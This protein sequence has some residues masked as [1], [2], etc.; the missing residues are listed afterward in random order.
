MKFKRITLF[1]T[2]GVLALWGCASNSDYDLTDGVDPEMTLFSDEV[3]TPIGSIGPLTVKTILDSSIGKLLTSI[4]KEGSDGLFY[5]EEEKEIGGIDAYEL[6]WRHADS[7][8]PFAWNP[9]TMSGYVSAASLLTMFG[10]SL[11]NQQLIVQATNPFDQAITLHTEAN[12]STADQSYSQSI[13]LPDFSLKNS[14]GKTTIAQFEIPSTVGQSINSVSLKDLS[15]DIPAEPGTRISSSSQPRIA[16]SFQY[17][18]NIAL[19]EKLNFPFALPTVKVS[20]DL[21]KYQIHKCQLVLEVQNTLPL[22]VTVNSIQVLTPTGKEGEDPVV[23][24][25]VTVTSGFTLA[26]GSLE[27]PVS[28]PLNLVIESTNGTIPD[29]AG[30]KVSINL[31]STPGLGTVP[32]SS[33]QGVFIKSSYVRLNGGITLFGHE[34][35]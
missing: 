7:K 5:L 10:L 35:N 34:E 27:A 28:T 15:V 18:T 31:Q 16:F 21:K 30:L 9:G 3:V 14:Y 20:V 24:E 17:K 26:G 33:K 8:E 32:L 11:T 23:A 13:P 25:N 6:A 22:S 4:L 12:A 19:G 1:L 29:I 2:L